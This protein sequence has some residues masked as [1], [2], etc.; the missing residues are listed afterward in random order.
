M[1]LK[2]GFYNL[3]S[4]DLV[5][6]WPFLCLAIC[7]YCLLPRISLFLLGSMARKRALAAVHF[8]R[9][10]HNQLVHR[11]LTP[12]LSTQQVASSSGE[13]TVED[14]SRGKEPLPDSETPEQEQSVAAVNGRLLAL[15][16]DE[17][18]DSCDQGELANYCTSRFGYSLEQVVRLDGQLELPKS[19]TGPLLLLQEAWQPPILELLDLVK[20]LREK[21][22]V[23]THII[24]ALIGKPQAET[25]F[26]PVSKLDMQ[27]WQTKIALLADPHLQLTP[28][29][30]M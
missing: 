15:I 19:C 29:V 16:P 9:A 12:R 25:L 5:S 18:Y 24:V 6:W 22:D 28:L 14:R 13:A 7:C 3:A 27:I 10:E 11:L 1:V 20:T 21:N 4:S 2:D 17:I 26:T 23:S 8:T 30:E